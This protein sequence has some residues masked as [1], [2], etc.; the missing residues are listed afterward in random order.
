MKLPG[1]LLCYVFKCFVSIKEVPRTGATSLF[2]TNAE[3]ALYLFFSPGMLSPGFDIRNI[4]FD[5]F[6]IKNHFR[7]W[8]HFTPSQKDQKKLKSHSEKLY[9]LN[10][11]LFIPLDYKSKSIS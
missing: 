8:F 9:S 5:I 10:E 6:S 11:T 1:P 7:L 4:V 2:D 3:A